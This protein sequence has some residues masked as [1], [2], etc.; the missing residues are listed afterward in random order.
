LA[1]WHADDLS[2]LKRRIICHADVPAGAIQEDLW[3][4]A[5]TVRHVL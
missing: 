5:I 2:K 1:L 3:A 4:K